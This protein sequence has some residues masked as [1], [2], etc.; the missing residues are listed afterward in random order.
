MTA[1]STTSPINSDTAQKT[2]T[3]QEY[4][5]GMARH[6]SDVA[7]ERHL[8]DEDFSNSKITAEIKKDEVD[9]RFK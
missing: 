3:H 9:F 1:S 6:A 7:S 5:S 2:K 8:L 4:S